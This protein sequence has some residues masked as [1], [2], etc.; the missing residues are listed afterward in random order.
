MMEEFTE[1]LHVQI[2]VVKEI[3]SINLDVKEFNYMRRLKMK[4]IVI[5]FMLHIETGC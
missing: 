3:L 1:R 5:I 4:G 2:L